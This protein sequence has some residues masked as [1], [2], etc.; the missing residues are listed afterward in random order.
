VNKPNADIEIIRK[1][2][3]GE[4]SPA[5]QYKLEKRALDDPF[6]Q[7]AMDG[8]ELFNVQ[9][10]NIN[11]LENRL[12][13]RINKKEKV[14]TIWGF[15]QWSVAASLI[16]GIAAFSIYFN[17]T[18]ENKTIA[19]SE[20]QKQELFPKS[21]KILEDTIT[22]TDDITLSDLT[23]NSLSIVQNDTPTALSSK[24]FSPAEEIT[25]EAKAVTNTDILKD[26]V[27]INQINVTA[28]NEQKKLDVNSL[29][30]KYSATEVAKTEAKSVLF[31]NALGLA[32]YKIDSQNIKQIVGKVIAIEGG[33]T[34]PGV[35]ISNPIKGDVVITDARGEFKIT[36]S[37]KDEITA[38][39]V[40]FITETIAINKNDSLIIALKVDQKS[41]SEVVASDYGNQQNSTQI[42][43]S[44]EGGWKEFRK[45]LDRNS[46]LIN[47]QK[48]KVIVQFIIQPDGKLSNIIIQ[49]SFNTIA[50]NK[51]IQLI[52]NY[53]TWFGSADKIAQKVEVT[54]RF[55]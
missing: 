27:T 41:L 45:Y 14:I 43:A 23:E 7:D 42:I 38:K 50:D 31:N 21:V 2:F 13:N 39:Y 1:Y 26:S 48:G 54:V 40:G 9:Q 35:Q 20:I 55:K 16:F 49:K 28:Y 12:A 51:A 17:Q 18:P 6:L 19:V 33:V 24:E 52:K 15:R 30:N 34:L 8:F 37:D 11:K 32:N 36:A 10:K 29:V 53:K 47:G 5:D 22:K 3:N 4:L 46:T 44:P 25:L